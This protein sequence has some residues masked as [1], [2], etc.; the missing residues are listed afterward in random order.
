MTPPKHEDAGQPIGGQFAK[1][2]HTEPTLTLGTPPISWDTPE[3]E[4]R[5]LTVMAFMAESDI[6]GTVTPLY[7]QYRAEDGTDAVILQTDDRNLVVHHAG[8]MSP[9]IAYGDDEDAAWSFRMEPGDT[10]LKTEHEVLADLVISARHDAACQ[11]AWRGDEDAFQSGEDVNVKDFGVRYSE[12]GTRIIT[13]DVERDGRFYELLQRGGDDVV[14]FLDDN[15][16]LPLPLV[17]LDALAFEFDEDHTEGTGDILFKG[18]MRDAA[19]RAAK[20]PGF[21]PRGINRP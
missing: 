6:E 19:D 3:D 13:L 18:M 5:F 20:D 8:S 4:A 15:K 10:T 14:I 2:K 7:T 17:Q 1:T 11:E 21:N 12:D 9:E 16:P